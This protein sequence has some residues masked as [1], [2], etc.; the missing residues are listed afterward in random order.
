MIAH[1]FSIPQMVE[2]VRLGLATATA[3]R[4]VSGKRK[5]EVATV[6]IT[7]AGRRALE[8]MKP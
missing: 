2:L 6:R 3:K 8:R 7:D 4:V 1:G 5:L